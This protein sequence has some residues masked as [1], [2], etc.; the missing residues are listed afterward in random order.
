MTL[1]AHPYAD[2]YPML[3]DDEHAE[4]VESIAANG[5]RNPVVVTPDGLILD[6]RNRAKACAE[7][8]IEPET[9]TY[10]GD[11]LAEYVI[12]VNG[13]RRHMSTGA[14]A[15]ADAL[16]LAEDGRRKG[17]R[18][19]RGSVDIGS[20]S[21]IES[22]WRKAI[23][24][25]GT[26]LDF[27]P[28]LAPAVVSGEMTLHNAYNEAQRVRATEEA[29]ERA[30]KARKKAEAEQ[31]KAD[32]QRDAKILADLTELDS[33][34]VALIEAGQLTAKAAWAAH[35][36][37]TEK[38]RK[39]RAEIER[40][41]RDTCNHIAECVYQLKGGEQLAAGFLREFYPH[42]S[43]YVPEGLRL[44]R[45]AIDSAISFLTHVRTGV[46]A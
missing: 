37:D 2:K 8:G 13:V 7:L 31:A 34:Y 17:G 16:V 45:E 27:A 25:A 30:E 21:N 3:P 38:E 1:Q 44:T 9:V 19:R 41:W 15:M 46:S 14:R 33:K 42:E 35:L 6:G 20:S 12:D 4:L 26:V 22:V 29:E 5:L 39:E 18:W 10:E 23:A 24:Q 32:S 43:K 28:D 36:A 40:G 11:D